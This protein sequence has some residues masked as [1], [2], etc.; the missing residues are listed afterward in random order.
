MFKH[1]GIVGKSVQ[2][3]EHTPLDV[4]PQMKR[5]KTESDRFA[6]VAGFVGETTDIASQNI[7]SVSIVPPKS[8]SFSHITP[9]PSQ[10]NESI[11]L[12]LRTAQQIANRLTGKESESKQMTKKRRWDR[13]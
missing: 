4:E 5:K 13:S 9:A 7:S 3:R 12:A 2:H 1:Q 8:N 11:Q 6:G 10:Q